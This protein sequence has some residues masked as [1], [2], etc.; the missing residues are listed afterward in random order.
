M[1]SVADFRSPAVVF[2]DLDGTFLAWSSY[3]PRIAAPALHRWRAAGV[4]VVFCSSK[5]GAEQR[6]LCDE[7]GVPDMPRIIENGA[8]IVVPDTA[9]LPTDSWATTPDEPGCKVRILGLMRYEID[10]RLARIRQ[11]TGLRLR[12]YREIDAAELA[13]ITGLSEAAAER[14]RARGYS[15]TIIDELTDE[16]RARLVPEFRA[17]GLERR[18]GG[19]FHTITGL[20]VDK[21]RAVRELTQLYTEA[22]AGKVC[23][24]GIGDS[25]NDE[26]LLLAVDQPFLVAREDGAWGEMDV[27]RLQRVTGRGPHGWVEIADRLMA[28]LS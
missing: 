16:Q 6:A 19:R 13:R 3:S 24:V 8:A 2:T 27:P 9:G 5:T 18:H 23:T 17:E 28:S 11:R 12:G 25:E 4:P 22:R 20:G 14:A 7:I 1:S 26:P 10:Q 21:G 15:E